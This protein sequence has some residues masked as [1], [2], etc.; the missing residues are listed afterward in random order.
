MM[1][2]EGLPESSID[3]IAARAGVAKGTFYHYF[4]SKAALIDALRSH[5]S[6]A[7]QASVVAAVD[8]RPP[9]DWDGRFEAWIVTATEAYFDMHALHDLVFHGP[10]MPQR[11]AL[12]DT[13]IVRHLAALVA[14]GQAS[15]AW[16][17]GGEEPAR[18][19]ALIFHAMHGMADDALAA[20]RSAGQLG[21]LI[22]RLS[23]R[24][25]AG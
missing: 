21:P 18:V 8:A 25:L 3:D 19:A 10:A 4:V 11:Q 22:A 9:G 14:E 15:G 23:K 24:M 13:D 20:G 6:D 7:F 5:F 2:D 12:D 16:H 1:V 17:L